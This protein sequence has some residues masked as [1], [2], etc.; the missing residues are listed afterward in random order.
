MNTKIT[1]HLINAEVEIAGGLRIKE[2]IIFDEEVT[3]FS[4]TINYKMVEEAWNK[5]GYGPSI[6]NGYSIENLE[7]AVL[8]SPDVVDFEI[9]NNTFSI[10]YYCLYIYFFAFLCRVVHRYHRFDAAFL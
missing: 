10:E 3:N 9:F 8:S 4:R 5:K 7:V 2:L 6:Y 1:S